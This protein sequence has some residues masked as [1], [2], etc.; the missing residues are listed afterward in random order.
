MLHSIMTRLLKQ[1]LEQE[2]LLLKPQSSVSK[3]V[4]DLLL[5]MPQA[6]FGSHFGS[7]LSE[8]LLNHPSVD[9]LFASD[10]ELTDMLRFLG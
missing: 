4:D 7:W 2:L 3:L 8:E 10:E 5:R 1:L 6:Q 9:E